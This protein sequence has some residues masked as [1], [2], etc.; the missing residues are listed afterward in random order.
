MDF[1]WAVLKV[2]ESSSLFQLVQSVY[3]LLGATS[4]TCSVLRVYTPNLFFRL[5]MTEPHQQVSSMATL[6]G[7]RGKTLLLLK[8]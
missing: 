6:S 1:Q 2:I 5:R 7:L 3:T 8:L 4:E